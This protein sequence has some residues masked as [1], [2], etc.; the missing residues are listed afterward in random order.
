M[1]TRTRGPKGFSLADNIQAGLF[2]SDNDRR[3]GIA[4]LIP[5]N[6]SLREIPVGEDLTV[7]LWAMFVHPAD[8]G[9]VFLAKSVSPKRQLKL[10]GA[11]AP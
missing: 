9:D 1:A 7:G 8:H 6:T 10:L 5:A 3:S 4:V 2:G 11:L